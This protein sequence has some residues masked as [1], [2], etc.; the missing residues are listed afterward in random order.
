[1][2]PN[3]KWIRPA[4]TTGDVCPV[5]SKQFSLF[6]SPNQSLSSVAHATLSVTAMGVYEASLNGK[7]I[8]DFVLAPGWTSYRHRLQVQTY[9]VTE[10]F[11]RKTNFPSSSEKVGTAVRLPGP[12]KRT[13]S[14]KHRFQ[15]D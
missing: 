10:L 5:Y 3:A 13:V 14:K 4:Q 1:M 9:D 6:S 7:R 15:P 8:G 12:M 11:L 2:I